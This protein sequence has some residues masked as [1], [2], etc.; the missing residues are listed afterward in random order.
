MIWY[1]IWY[2]MIY[3]TAIGLTPGGSSTS[4]IYTQTVQFT[5]KQYSLHTNNTY[6]QQQ[7][8]KDY[9]SNWQTGLLRYTFIFL[10]PNLNCARGKKCRFYLH[11]YKLREHYEK[12]QQLHLMD[13]CRKY[14]KVSAKKLIQFNVVHSLLVTKYEATEV[15]LVSF[16]SKTRH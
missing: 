4:H 11:R 3:L 12:F 15:W 1:D 2:D 7:C 16:N 9:C 6:N 8:W 10:H 5:H 13:S 14:M